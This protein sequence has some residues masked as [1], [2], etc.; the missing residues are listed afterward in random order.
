VFTRI[1]ASCV[2]AFILLE[3]VTLVA[4]QDRLELTR[5]SLNVPTGWASTVEGE[6]WMLHLAGSANEL[7]IVPVGTGLVLGPR[8]TR[9][10]ARRQLWA[11]A[12]GS[13]RVLQ[14]NQTQE[15]KGDDGRTWSLPT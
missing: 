13:H 12:L 14:A 9:A 8:L 3:G 5:Y 10:D 7:A 15:Q 4:A 11:T 2:L 6:R 1:V